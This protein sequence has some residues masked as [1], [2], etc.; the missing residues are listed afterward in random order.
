MLCVLI[1]QEVIKEISVM[2]LSK[3]NLS[4]T[5]LFKREEK[6]VERNIIIFFTVLLSSLSMLLNKQSK[7][8][9]VWI[10]LEMFC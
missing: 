8:L 10:A 1:I 9:N 3:E 4:R 2:L 5:V 7:N 6:F